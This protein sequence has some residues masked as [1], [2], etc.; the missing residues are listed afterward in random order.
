MAGRLQFFMRPFLPLAIAF[1]LISGCSTAG[2]VHGAT[3][4]DSIVTT[5]S[6]S[7]PG[8]RDVV[9]PVAAPAGD[10]FPAAALP[11]ERSAPAATPAADAPERPNTLAPGFLIRLGHQEDRDLNGSFRI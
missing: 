7:D 6:A 1:A 11:P 9:D 4:T 8:N 10:S 2:R 3:S 5:S